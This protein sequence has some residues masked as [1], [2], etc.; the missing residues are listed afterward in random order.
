MFWLCH[1]IAPR[2]H[3]LIG[4]AV[5][6]QKVTAG[7]IH[8]ARVV[9]CSYLQGWLGGCTEFAYLWFPIIGNLWGCIHWSCRH[10]TTIC[11]D[12][13]RAR[14]RRLRLYLLFTFYSLRKLYFTTLFWCLLVHGS[15]WEYQYCAI[16]KLY[17]RYEFLAQVGQKSCSVFYSTFWCQ[18]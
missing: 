3:F 13:A 7:G 6:L 1:S 10:V 11:T 14:H 2:T 9:W 17:Y 8:I 15:E 18:L 5:F 12:G 4:L 16:Q